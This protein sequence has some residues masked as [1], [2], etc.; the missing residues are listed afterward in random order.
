MRGQQ[1]LGAKEY[2]WAQVAKVRMLLVGSKK[3][4][5]Q[6]KGKRGARLVQ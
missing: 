5:G 6:A 2:C 3:A 1:L 4:V